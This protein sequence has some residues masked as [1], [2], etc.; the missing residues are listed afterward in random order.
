M[1]HVLGF[2]S[3]TEVIVLLVIALLLFGATRLP[4]LAR[5]MG[6]SVGEFKKGLREGNEEAAKGADAKDA[7]PETTEAK[8]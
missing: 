7:A 5:S 3:T 4:K 1:P 8:K 6:M 2:L